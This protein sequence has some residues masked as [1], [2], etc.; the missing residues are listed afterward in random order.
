MACYNR[1]ILRSES[2]SDILNFV[3]IFKNEIFDKTYE[4]NIKE[5]LEKNQ[6]KENL[7]EHTK[8]IDFLSTVD[9]PDDQIIELCN[10]FP[11]MRMEIIFFNIEDQFY[12][13]AHYEKDGYS[14]T[15]EE[16]IVPRE[17]IH[18]KSD[19]TITRNITEATKCE[20]SGDFRK[21]LNDH[22]M[23]FQWNMRHTL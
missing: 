20:A 19:G 7:I 23:P 14:V 1:L 12:G 4:L 10:E 16:D 5:N 11:N 18:R 2:V 13:E 21:F 15:R 17:L 6:I 8:T 9:C 22:K 3:S